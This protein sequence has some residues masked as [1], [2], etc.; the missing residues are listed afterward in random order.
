MNEGCR[1]KDEVE[2]SLLGFYRYIERFEGAED[3]EKSEKN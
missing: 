2:V 1:E 3:K